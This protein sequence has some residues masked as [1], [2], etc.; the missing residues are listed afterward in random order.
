MFGHL[1][2]E[3]NVLDLEDEERTALGDVIALHRRFRPLLHGGDAV[4]FDL[5]PN[6]PGGRD[7]VPDA[8]AH[9]VYA[10]DRGEALVCFAQLRTGMALTPPPLRLPGLAP[11]RAYRIENV[12]LPGGLRGSSRTLPEWLT[13]PR[14][15]FALTGAQLAA[16]GIQLPVLWPETAMLLH[17]SI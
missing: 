13:E 3:W 10:I 16:H 1:G 7:S 14:A 6:G 12:P 11:E 4:R 15:D 2:V 9:G 5:A 17:L 8:M